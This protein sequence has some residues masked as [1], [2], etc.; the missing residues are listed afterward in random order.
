MRRILVVLGML[1]LVPIGAHAQQQRP[2]NMA[3][4][5]ERERLEREIVQ[6]F[7]QQVSTALNLDDA[8]RSRLET[9][10]NDGNARRRGLAREAMQLRQRLQAAVRDSS[11][12]EAEYERIL[13]G[14]SAIRDQEH[15][16]W[17]EE[18]AALDA[19]LSPRERAQFTMHW[20]RFQQRIRELIARRPGAPPR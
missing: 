7:V 19:L 16:N 9:L 12:A 14:M 20:L 15:A 6:R 3:R 10:L 4:P 8:R 17:R 1:L 2:S 18:Q 13:S 5:A 11:T